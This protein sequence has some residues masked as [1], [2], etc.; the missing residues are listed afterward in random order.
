MTGEEDIKPE[1][2][3]RSRDLR[4]SPASSVPGIGNRLSRRRFLA[5]AGG[6]LVLGAAGCDGGQDA[7]SGASGAGRIIEHKYGTTEISGAP[8]R[9]VSVGF[10]DQDPILALG[11]A[12]VAV[13]EFTGER[14]YATW[15]W[16][17]DDLG[18]ARPRVLA[19]GELNF[20]QIAALEPDLIVGVSSGMSE[21]EY[22]F[23]SEIAPTLAQSDAYADFGVPWQEQTRVIGRTLGRRG[24][25]ESLVADLEARFEDARGQHPEFEGTRAVS[26]LP[27]TEAGQYFVSSP[28]APT[29]RFMGALGFEI[30]PQVAGLPSDVVTGTPVGAERLDLLDTGD[31]LVWRLQSPEQRQAVE[32]DRI[33]R[34]LDVV[35]EGRDIFLEGEL[36]AALSFSTVL[37]LPVALDELV[38]RISATIDGDP[39]TQTTR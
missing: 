22:G 5:G 35:R 11:V 13:R 10:T 36:N 17:R 1:T 12:P 14:P 28:E 39:K 4:L 9:V 33:Y 2:T 34:Q 20:E 24:E 16:A 25:A 38:P 29:S 31:V 26:A 32:N 3:G 18:D 27:S 37:S 8:E 23:L 6:L 7:G 19:V 15:P 21:E 30:P